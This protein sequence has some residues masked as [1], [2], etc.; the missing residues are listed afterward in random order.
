MAT[1]ALAALARRTGRR[2]Q[3]ASPV[4]ACIRIASPRAVMLRRCGR[5]AARLC[6][7]AALLLAGLAS[8]LAALAAPLLG[9]GERSRAAAR[10]ACKLAWTPALRVLP[11]VTLAETPSAAAWDAFAGDAASGA[12]LLLNHAS[13]FD[14]LVFV[15]LCPWRVVARLPLRVLVHA[16]HFR[17]PLFGR[18]CAACGH[19]PV[20]LEPRAEAPGRHVN[21]ALQA[22]AQACSLYF[23]VSSFDAASARR[24]AS[25][26][27]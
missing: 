7:V 20:H 11:W 18:V 2:R 6:F 9:G 17:L 23:F 14:P 16:A 21:R 1:G 8:W 13:G 26:M 24:R 25:W 12:L 27:T 3:V 15:A 4:P 10:C 22:R 5:E 19:F